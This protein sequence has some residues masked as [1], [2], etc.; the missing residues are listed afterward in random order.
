MCM[1]RMKVSQFLASESGAVTVDWTVLAAAIVGLGVATVGAVRSGVI[2][3][4]GDIETS[5][6][7]ASVASLGMLGGDGWEFDV[8]YVQSL[9]WMH[10]PSGFI[11]QI[12]AWNYTPAQLQTAYDSYARSAQLYINQGN[13]SIA[14][15]MV[16]HM[17]AVEQIL[18]SQGVALSSTSSSVRSMYDAVTGM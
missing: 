11:A 2:S 1:S 13:A 7:S 14:G 18:M 17:Y 12:S 8:L 3:L 4:G 6:S 10:G 15:L 9:E 5:L 16:D